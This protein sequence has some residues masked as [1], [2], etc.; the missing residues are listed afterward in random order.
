MPQVGAIAKR[1]CCG[2][3]CDATPPERG[4]FFVRIKSSNRV[5][6]RQA[7]HGTHPPHHGGPLHFSGTRTQFFIDREEPNTKI[8][9]Y[10]TWGKSLPNYRS[11]LLTRKKLIPTYP[12]LLT[13]QQLIAK[14]SK[15][16]RIELSSHQ[17][18]SLMPPLKHKVLTPS[19]LSLQSNLNKKYKVVSVEPE[20]MAYHRRPRVSM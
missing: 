14:C 8:H 7:A 10:N 20:S 16:F 6:R 5:R 15:V 18:H 11:V 2:R 3:R 4:S 19:Y 9:T 13:K 1:F 12:P 17:V